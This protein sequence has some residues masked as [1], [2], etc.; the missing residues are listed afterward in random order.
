VRAA[1]CQHRRPA[2]N[3]SCHRLAIRGLMSGLTAAVIPII[4]QGADVAE[5]RTVSTS[6]TGSCWP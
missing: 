6:L 1:R 4:A 5:D 2:A 3:S